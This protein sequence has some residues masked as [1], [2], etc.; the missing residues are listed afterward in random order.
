VIVLPF[1]RVHLQAPVCDVAQGPD[2]Q[3]F[4]LRVMVVWL[5]RGRALPSDP[6]PMTRGL[7]PKE[8]VI[9]TLCGLPDGRAGG[10]F[11]V[12]A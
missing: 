1:C 4:W 10:G 9:E 6:G 2:V 7:A 3:R 12:S 8:S 11:R 5:C